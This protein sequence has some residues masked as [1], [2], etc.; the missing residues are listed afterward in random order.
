[1]ARLQVLPYMTLEESPV[2]FMTP[3][4]KLLAHC[5]KNTLSSSQTGYICNSPS[6][7]HVQFLSLECSSLIST[8]LAPSFTSGLSYTATISGLPG[9]LCMKQ[10]FQH[11]S[12]LFSPALLFFLAVIIT[13]NII[14]F[15]KIYTVTSMKVG[16]L[17]V[18]FTII[19]TVP[20]IMPVTRYIPSVYVE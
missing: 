9:P 15:K 1:M 3:P 17:S 14:R 4:P 16:T 11:Q 18:L 5:F 13:W 6:L 19:S 12:Q 20:T 2:D 8:R 7:P 10:F